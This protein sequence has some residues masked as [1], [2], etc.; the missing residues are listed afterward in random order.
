MSSSFYCCPECQF[1][2]DAIYWE[3]GRR[4]VET[5]QAGAVRAN[6]GDE[7]IKQ[8]ANDLSTQIWAAD[9]AL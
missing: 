6:Y 2:Y 7:L 8:L 3:I 5:E 1:H 9:L 4:I